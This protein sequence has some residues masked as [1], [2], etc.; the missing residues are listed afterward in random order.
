MKLPPQHGG[1]AEPQGLN[2][3]PLSSLGMFPT[4]SKA[5]ERPHLV[6]QEIDFW[7]GCSVF[8]RGYFC[9]FISLIPP[10]YIRV[11]R[12]FFFFFA[13]L[14]RSLP[15]EAPTP[16]AGAGIAR[17]SLVRPLPTRDGHVVPSWARAKG[18]QLQ[19][20][21][22]GARVTSFQPGMGFTPC[23]FPR[24]LRDAGRAQ[25]FKASHSQWSWE[26]AAAPGRQNP[27]GAEGEGGVPPT[28]ASSLSASERS[29]TGQNRNLL[30]L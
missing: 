16:L 21:L 18:H 6:L 28:A 5:L 27:G 13:C 8:T 3:L 23:T 2:F 12:N 29:G 30:F 1:R 9:A 17:Q 25:E 15:R 14:Q 20:N 22:Q 19:L 24:M 11:I 26:A 10:A 4:R 7:A